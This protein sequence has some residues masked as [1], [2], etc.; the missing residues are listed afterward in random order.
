MVHRILKTGL[1]RDKNSQLG[2][3]KFCKTFG[4]Q[5]SFFSDFLSIFSTTTNEP[6]QNKRVNHQTITVYERNS[7]ATI[8]EDTESVQ[9]RHLEC[10]TCA[11]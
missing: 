3:L 4:E 7:F 11:I 6:L 2:N 1:I 8:Y 5:M 9:N 10:G